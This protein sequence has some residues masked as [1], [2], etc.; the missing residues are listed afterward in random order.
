HISN[1]RKVKRIQDVI[2]T[3][4]IIQENVKSKLI[5]VGDGPELQTAFE[6]VNKLNLKNKVL[7]LGKQKNISD[8]LSISDIKL[9]MSEQES[10]GLVLLEAMACE[11]ATIGTNVGGIPE[12]ISHGETGY[13]VELGDTEAAA[14]Y[15]IH[16]LKDEDLLK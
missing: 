13:V 2:Y 15:A 11:V 9:L 5:L 12:V 14:K 4:S 1:F 16:L 8:L 6:V 7:F 3:F 10:F